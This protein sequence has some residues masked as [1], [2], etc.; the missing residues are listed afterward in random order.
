MSIQKRA[1]LAIGLIASLGIALAVPQGAQAAPRDR[2]VDRAFVDCPRGSMLEVD[3]EREGRKL[4]AD[5]DIYAN[6][7]ERWT[8]TFSQNGRHMARISRA[9]NRE[10]ELNVSRYLP[11]RS[12][13][14]QVS[15][16]SASG[17]RCMASVR[18]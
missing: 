1:L 3:L 9:A 16:R 18:F 10:G 14:V 13:V 4:E 6:P 11:L 5:V 8:V 17:E 2:I 7:R 12:G 15:A